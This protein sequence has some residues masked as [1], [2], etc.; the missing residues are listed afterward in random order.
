MNGTCAEPPTRETEMPGLMAGRRPELKRSVSRKICPSVMEITL[1]GTKAETS[2]AWVSMIG[3]A[4]SEP[5]WPFTSPLV[6]CSTY[7]AL[8]RAARSRRREWR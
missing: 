1:V 6:T 3:S 8:T 7:S 4:V 2:P 5:V